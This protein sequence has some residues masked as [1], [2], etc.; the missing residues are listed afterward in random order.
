MASGTANSSALCD[1]HSGQ[2]DCLPTVGGRDCDTCVPGYFNYDP[3]DNPP[4]LKCDCFVGGS[5]SNVCNTA[6]GDCECRSNIGGVVTNL[7]GVGRDVVVCD[8]ALSGFFCH[9]LALVSEAEGEELAGRDIVQG[10]ST[11]LFTGSGFVQLPANKS[12]TITNISVPFC[13]EYDLFLKHAP[14]GGP[15]NRVKIVIRNTTPLVLSP[16]APPPCPPL[17]KEVVELSLSLGSFTQLPLSACLLAEGS[18]YSAVV[19]SHSGPVLVDALLATPS[20]G[21]AAGQLEV[22][23]DEEVLQRYRDEECILEHVR[24]VGVSPPS[25]DLFC[26]RVTCS[27]S[28]QLFN[29]ALGKEDGFTV[30]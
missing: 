7:L 19:T 27:A 21:A 5:V 9:R 14:P 25:D 26:E 13:G 11:E 4:C 30:L 2:C 12:L 29:G 6:T 28:Y 16:E 20:L 3:L 17:V 22:F 23:A 18:Y 8:S 15:G 24:V 10:S 1:K